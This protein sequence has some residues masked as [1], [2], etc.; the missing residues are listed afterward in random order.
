M[1]LSTGDQ[2]ATGSPV[3]ISTGIRSS[4]AFFQ[5]GSRRGSSVGT[6]LPDLSVRN[7]PRFLKIFRPTAP[8]FTS[9]SSCLRRGRAEVRLVDAAE[10]DVRERDEALR[11]ARRAASARPCCSA[12]PEPPLR[13]TITAR[14]MRSMSATSLSTSAGRHVAALMIV[15][16]DER[17]TSPACADAPA[18]PAST[19]A[20]T[21]RTSSLRRLRPER[22]ADD[23]DE[24]GRV[25]GEDRRRMLSAPMHARTL[26]SVFSHVSVSVL[27]FCAGR[28]R[29]R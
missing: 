14:P 29:A 3:W 21:P 1:C 11:I 20:R 23:A 17:D 9:S 16:V 10:V 12:S 8:F 25:S 15:D 19:S 13:L 28:R 18:P 4:P 2:N 6:R 5:I 22:G 27:S 24:R 7:M 26:A